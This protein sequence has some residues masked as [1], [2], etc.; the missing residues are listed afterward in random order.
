MAPQIEIQWRLGFLE[1]MQYDQIF[2][3][4]VF[5]I[6]WRAPGALLES[7]EV[8][9]HHAGTPYLYDLAAARPPAK[10]EGHFQ[11]THGTF[12]YISPNSCPDIDREP[13][14]ND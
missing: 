3:S 4:N 5:R 7:R 6:V 2:Q 9:L 14:Q 8:V 10:L 13:N 12:E 11:G 1:A